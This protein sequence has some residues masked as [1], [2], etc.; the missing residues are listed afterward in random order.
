MAVL[1]DRRSLFGIRN[2]LEH[3]VKNPIVARLTLHLPEILEETTLSEQQREKLGG[4]IVD[5]LLKK[6]LRCWEIEQARPSKA[7]AVRG[8]LGPSTFSKIASARSWS[9]RAV[10]KSPCIC[11]SPA[12]LS[13]AH[14]VS[15]CSGPSTFSKI[16]SA[17]SWSGRAAAKSPWARRQTARL[18]RL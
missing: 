3:D 11:N 1:Q 15:G 4:I 7:H 6:L 9:R 2:T 12:R 16:A 17:R 13:K 10:A 14:A 8:C 18:L 5:S